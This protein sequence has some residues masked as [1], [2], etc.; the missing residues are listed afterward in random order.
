MEMY[1]SNLAS[2]CG[3]IQLM[4]IGLNPNYSKTLACC[5]LLYHVQ[6]QKSLQINEML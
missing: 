5:C 4:K 2:T 6:F 1:P 3:R